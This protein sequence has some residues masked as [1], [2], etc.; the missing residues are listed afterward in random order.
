MVIYGNNS[1]IDSLPYI[2]KKSMEEI[3]QWKRIFI[4][5]EQSALSNVTTNK[6][7]E[8]TTGWNS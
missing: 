7:P 6:K 2:V 3:F 8:A 4:E 5:E 1:S